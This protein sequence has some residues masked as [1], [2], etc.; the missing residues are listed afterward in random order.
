[1]KTTVEEITVKFSDA[2]PGMVY[3]RVPNDPTPHIIPSA[4]DAASFIKRWCKKR[5]DG[6]HVAVVTWENIPAGFV[7]PEVPS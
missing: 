7:P 2:R 1:M 5:A 4:E 6:M 3:V